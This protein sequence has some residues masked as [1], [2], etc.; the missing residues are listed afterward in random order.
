MSYVMM[1]LGSFQF[2]LDTATFQEMSRSTQWRWAEQET[3]GTLPTSQYTGP[4]KETI[5]LKGVIFPEFR[6]G[7]SQLHSLRGLGDMGFPHMLVSGEGAIMGRF[8]IEQVDE[9]QTVFDTF[10][11]PRRQEFTIQLKRFS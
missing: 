8:C 1:Q 9:G 6:G 5:T 11:R 10:G 2:A 7:F 4:G 3:Y